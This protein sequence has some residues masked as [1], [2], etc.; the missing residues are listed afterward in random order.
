MI[1]QPEVRSSASPIGTVTLLFTDIEGSTNLLGR[2]QERYQE[3]LK[4]HHAIVRRALARWNGREVDTEGDSFFA[5]F[6]RASTKKR[7][8][9]F[10][11]G[12]CARWT[13]TIRQPPIMP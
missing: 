8:R 13:T 1:E 9:I 10:T 11:T 6:A 12:F 7:R 2:L 3:L 5:V 4:A